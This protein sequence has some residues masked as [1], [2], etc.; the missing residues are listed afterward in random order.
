MGEFKYTPTREVAERH[1]AAAP[2]ESARP[3]I[4]KPAATVN[5][6][7][8][9]DLGSVRY[10]RV[11]RLAYG[12]PPLAYQT[13][14]RILDAYTRAIAL[15]R[16]MAGKIS[17]QATKEEYYR[18]L[19]RLRTLLWKASFPAGRFRRVLWHLGLI[20]NQ[21]RRATE[22]ELLDIADFFLRGRTMSTVQSLSAHP[23]SSGV[24][25]T[26]MR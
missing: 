12:V 24:Q 3:A 5:V 26:P 21:L 14:H 1:R 10:Y 16:V 19:D 8:V 23:A 18:T 9:L 17:D 6:Q 15:A 22:Q 2:R 4:A 25:A 7:P 13:G 11:G 20:P